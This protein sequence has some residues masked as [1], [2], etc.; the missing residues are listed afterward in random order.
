MSQLLKNRDVPV[1]FNIASLIEEV[2]TDLVNL[3]IDEKDIRKRQDFEKQL[4]WYTHLPFWFVEHTGTLTS[5]HASGRRDYDSVD[6]LYT[7]F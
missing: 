2:L 4:S 7:E 3:S 5:T 1:A 6:L